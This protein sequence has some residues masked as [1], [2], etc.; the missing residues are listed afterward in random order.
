MGD[1]MVLDIYDGLWISSLA[2][3][4]VFIRS[5]IYAKRDNIKRTDKE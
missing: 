3:L 4:I 1:F 5:V 2:T